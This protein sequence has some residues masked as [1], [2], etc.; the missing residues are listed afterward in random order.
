MSEYPVD[1]GGCA[2][3]ASRDRFEGLV[4]W[5]GDAATGGLT[6]AELED[7]VDRCG[8]EVMRQL[9]QDRLDLTAMRER[10]VPGGVVGTDDGVTRTR[11]EAGR[12]LRLGTE[13][14]HRDR[15]PCSPPTRD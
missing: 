2:F 3:G 8:R 12:T 4:A 15:R 9:I 6:H 1:E 13:F 11:V 5:L 14:G 7:A 10:P